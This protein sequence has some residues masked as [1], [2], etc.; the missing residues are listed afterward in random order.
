MPNRRVAGCSQRTRRRGQKAVILHGTL[1]STPHHAVQQQ[2]SKARD[3]LRLRLLLLLL[4]CTC[5]FH[6]IIP[7]MAQALALLAI[8][9]PSP[10]GRPWEPPSQSS[11]PCR[12]T[13][14]PWPMYFAPLSRSS[15]EH[16]QA[17]YAV[18]RGVVWV[19]VLLDG[20]NAFFV[21]E[22]SCT[23]QA[24]ALSGPSRFSMFMHDM[25]GI[26]SVTVRERPGRPKYRLFCLHSLIAFDVYIWDPIPS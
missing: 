2:R 23:C 8:R 10:P 11:I 3:A 14:Y 22:H 6:P 21:N 25:V 7:S 1:E 16:Q 19:D 26:G 12:T 15:L 13:P 5:H 4:T 17:F 18:V 24:V 9:T 20:F